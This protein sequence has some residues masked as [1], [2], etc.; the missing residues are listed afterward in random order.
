MSSYVLNLRTTDPV[1]RPDGRNE[2]SIIYEWD[3]DASKAQTIA[4][5]PYCADQ[6][7][8]P[9]YVE[10]AWEDFAATYRGRPA[11]DAEKLDP[12]QIKGF[13]IMARSNFGVS[14]TRKR[15][16]P[17]SS[18]IHNMSVMPILMYFMCVLRNNRATLSCA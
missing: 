3:F 2:S 9:A 4:D 17:S 16:N 11:E 5:Q 6:H 18:P 12:A 8:T 10:A 1:K 15:S 14:E 7:G 13:S